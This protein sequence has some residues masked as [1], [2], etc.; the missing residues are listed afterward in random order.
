MSNDLMQHPKF[1][2]SALIIASGTP[3]Q[4]LFKHTLN[5]CLAWCALALQLTIVL[6]C[7]GLV[8]LVAKWDPW[9]VGEEAWISI[10]KKRL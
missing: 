2:N 4:H 10:W 5:T 6:F 3:N 7:F 1:S 8:S 9:P